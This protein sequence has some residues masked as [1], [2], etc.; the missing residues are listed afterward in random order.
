[1]PDGATIGLIVCFCLMVVMVVAGLIASNVAS[2]KNRRGYMLFYF[3]L[4]IVFMIGSFILTG[5]M[6]DN[7]KDEPSTT[8]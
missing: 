3:G 6:A 4:A 8:P 1:M 2:R 5:I 7:K